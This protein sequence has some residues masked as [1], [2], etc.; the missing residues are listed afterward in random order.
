LTALEPG[1]QGGLPDA[2]AAK[3]DAGG[4]APAIT[5]KTEM[6]SHPAQAASSPSEA[7]AGRGKWAVLLAVGVG[8]FMGALDGSV[9]NTIL[10]VVRSE[11]GV[12][13][14]TIEWVVTIYL[15]TVTGLLLTFGRLGD[16]RGNKPVY[17][18]GFGLFLLGSVLSARASTAGFLIL[19][20]CVQGMGAAMLASNS[21]AILTR[22]FPSSE[23]GRALGIQSMMTYLGLMVGP[24]LGGWLAQSAGWRSVFYINLPVGALALGLGYLA[25]PGGKPADNKESFDV[26]GALVFMGGLVSMLLALSLGPGWGWLSPGILLQLGVAGVLLTAFIV[27]EKR[28][29]NPMLDLTL[30]RSRT[31]SVAAV[32]AVLNYVCLFSVVFLMPF[33]LIQGRGLTAAQAGLLLTAQPLVMVVAAPIS[34]TLS[35]RMG[36]RILSSLGMALMGLGMIGLALLRP[37]TDLLVVAAALGVVGLGTGIF[38]SP[39]SSALMGSAPRQRQGIAAGIMATSRS[40][41]MVLGVALSAA[42]LASILAGAL[43]MLPSEGLLYPAISFG[44]GVMALVAFGGAALSFLRS[45]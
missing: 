36:S 26:P 42:I 44:L 33:Y 41:G 4:A 11:F 2:R 17:L 23:R 20:R 32:S 40:F 24:A 21:P 5:A 12:N 19:A 39:N 29:A 13:I 15:L 25:I 10:P 27:I 43:P 30:F 16:L 28:V 1:P 8:T 37:S 7:L 38:I 34:G 6:K 31:F 3:G 35:D 14:S 22:S 9:V 45:S 18:G